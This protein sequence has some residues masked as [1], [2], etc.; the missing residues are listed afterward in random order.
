MLLGDRFV[1]HNSPAFRVPQALQ[2]PID[3]VSGGYSVPDDEVKK[4]DRPCRIARSISGLGRLSE[5]G[6]S[7][8]GRRRVALETAKFIHRSYLARHG[9]PSMYAF[10]CSYLRRRPCRITDQHAVARLGCHRM[11][12]TSCWHG[13]PATRTRHQ[14][15]GARACA[16]WC[17]NSAANPARPTRAS[18]NEQGVDLL[19]HISRPSKARRLA[20]R[21][22]RAGGAE[23]TRM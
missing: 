6:V 2:A 19:R 7:H 5:E 13:G 9:N 3:I 23:R 21:C 17:C 15:G 14:G 18:S 16:S 1:S 4:S 10:G 12:K 22:R 20:G 8:N 11:R